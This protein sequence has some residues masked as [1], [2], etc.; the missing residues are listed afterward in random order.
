HLFF[1]LKAKRQSRARTFG[2]AEGTL[3]RKKQEKS[4]SFFSCF[5]SHLFVPL[6]PQSRDC[7]ENKTL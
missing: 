5:F 4:F 1:A 7:D 3:V 2:Y 6:Q